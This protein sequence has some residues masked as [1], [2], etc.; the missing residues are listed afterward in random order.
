MHI[1][2]EVEMLNYLVRRIK[3]QER[4]LVAY[5]VGAQPSDTTLDTLSGTQDWQSVLNQYL[6]VKDKDNET[7]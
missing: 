6:K 7:T 2:S 1:K 4:L 3:A 5:R